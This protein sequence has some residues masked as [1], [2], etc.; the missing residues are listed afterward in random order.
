MSSFHIRSYADQYIDGEILGVGD[1]KKFGPEGATL[2]ETVAWVP[3]MSAFEGYPGLLVQERSSADGSVVQEGRFSTVGEVDLES[4]L[5]SGAF[6]YRSGRLS[7]VRFKA[8]PGPGNPVKAYYLFDCSTPL[9]AD[10]T[11]DWDY[12]LERGRI[13]DAQ[14]Q[15]RTHNEAEGDPE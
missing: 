7:G 2:E 11:V 15:G 1:G 5:L 6:N 12:L 9:K 13:R 14:E 10:G 4:D 3:V 8:A